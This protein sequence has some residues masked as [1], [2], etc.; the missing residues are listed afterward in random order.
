[1][2]W[3]IAPDR[4]LIGKHRWLPRWRFQP[5]ERL[6]DAFRLLE[7]ASP[8][9]YSMGSGNAASWARVQIAGS[10]GEAHDGS[11]P[12]AITYAVARAIGISIE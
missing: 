3:G 7:G 6:E 9:D 4:F 1:M 2:S 11:K 10:I 8:D 12:R 5:T